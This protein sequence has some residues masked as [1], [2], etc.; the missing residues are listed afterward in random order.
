MK[1]LGNVRNTLLKNQSQKRSSIQN[2]ESCVVRRIEDD[3]D[4]RLSIAL[5]GNQSGSS[6][7][8]HASNHEDRVTSG[9]GNT[10]N[11]G[12]IQLDIERRGDFT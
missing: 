8:S 9:T 10:F 11:A 12:S 1:I 3:K 7:K 4:G 2:H 5:D 6:G